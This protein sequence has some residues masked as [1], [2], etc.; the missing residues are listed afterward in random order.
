MTPPNPI[1]KR[2]TPR[3]VT[4][5]R[6]ATR[7]ITLGPTAT[8]NVTTHTHV[9]PQ[10]TARLVFITLLA[11]SEDEEMPTNTPY[12]SFALPYPIRVDN[13][14]D[15]VNDLPSPYNRPALHLLT[16]THSDHLIG[17]ASK[18]FGYQIICSPDAKEMLLRHEVYAERSLFDHEYRAQKTKTYSHLKVEPCV[19]P[20]G[21]RFYAGSRDLLRAVPLHT[22]TEFELY[23]NE[24]VSITLIDANHCPGAVMFL[25]EG[26][27]GSVLHTGDMRAE[28]WFLSSLS[29]NPFLQRYLADSAENLNILVARNEVTHMEATGLV[30]TLE[31]I[32]LDTASLLSI[33]VI[34]SK[35]SYVPIIFESAVQGLI[36]LIALFPSTTFFF[37]N[38][39]TWGYEDI[40]KGIAFAFRCKIHFDRYKYAIYTHTSDPLMR[41]LGT[42][43]PSSTRFHACERFDRCSFVDVPPHECG[44]ER[45]TTPLSMEGKRVVYVDPVTM[46]SAQWDRYKA[47]IKRHLLRGENVDSLLV[48]LSRHSPLPELMNFV[49]LF[50]PLRVIPNTLHSS[51]DG[52]DWRVMSAMFESCV[53]P[54]PGPQVHSSFSSVTAPLCPLASNTKPESFLQHTTLLTSKA[55]PLFVNPALGNE[56]IDAAIQNLVGPSSAAEKWVDMGD[57]R[58][59]LKVINMWLP[60]GNKSK[61]QQMQSLRWNE[62]D[63]CSGTSVAGPSRM[64]N[65]SASNR[66]SVFSSRLDVSKIK[67]SRSAADSDESSDEGGSNDHA[68]TAWILFGTGHPDGTPTSGASSSHSGTPPRTIGEVGIFPTPVASPVFGLSADIPHTTNLQCMTTELIRQADNPSLSPLSLSSPSVQS[69]SSKFPCNSPFESLDRLEFM[70]SNSTP[71]DEFQ[72]QHLQGD[73]EPFACI[74][75]VL[76]SQK[77]VDPDPLTSDVQTQHTQ[78]QRQDSIYGGRQQKRTLGE[79]E[80][81]ALQSENSPPCMKRPRLDQ[82][83]PPMPLEAGKDVKT[84]AYNQSVSNSPIIVTP[85][86]QKPTDVNETALLVP[87]SLKAVRSTPALPALTFPVSGADESGQPFPKAAHLP[88]RLTKASSTSACLRSAASP[89]KIITADRTFCTASEGIHDSSTISSPISPRTAERRA[90]RRERKVLTEKLRLARPDLAQTSKPTKQRPMRVTSHAEQC[91]SLVSSSHSSS[92]L[93]S[94]SI[95]NPTWN[96]RYTQKTNI[97]SERSLRLAEEERL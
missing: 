11:V 15:T 30:K 76:A 50:R 25:I 71:K 58:S 96:S 74:N 10:P 23:D 61:V 32:Y 21:E 37:I 43:D 39:W 84:D 77:T 59:K 73:A 67:E 1:L 26:P 46:G 28:P 31:A 44:V 19:M 95:T 7:V 18:S 69:P 66:L 16:H 33:T 85:N 65:S 60:G 34:P 9:R 36:E 83:R 24:T 6:D 42:R 52:L 8:T 70:I 72:E 29:R 91:P 27:R 82:E 54:L 3:H 53:S 88:L 51:L 22:P 90:R 13:F 45:I 80:K 4:M 75:N 62:L 35:A 92:V 5:E 94:N 38:S 40:L 86:A 68:H 56:E 93:P 47:E 64:A 12:H 48:P 57:K 41:A 49:S 2:V 20:N 17:L 89:T 97:D 81:Y 78:S 63:N 87:A 55:E 79:V 14:T